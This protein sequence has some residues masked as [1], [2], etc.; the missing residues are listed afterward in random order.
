M[1]K[2][3]TIF[4]LAFA[5]FGVSMSAQSSNKDFIYKKR[6]LSNKYMFQSQE[7]KLGEMKHIFEK[8][9]LTSSLYQKH[10]RQTKFFKTTAITAVSVVVLGIGT[11][12][13][14]SQTG[15][16]YDALIALGVSFFLSVTTGA[17][18]IGAGLASLVSKSRLKKTF[19]KFQSTMYG[20]EVPSLEFGLAQN[21]LGF[22]LRF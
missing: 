18:S 5:F 7:Y 20:Y 19:N 4:S 17:I 12:I 14:I 21:R 2:I 10:R 16:F 8:H 11:S 3:I 13:L 22:T 6:F 15:D 9:Q 1:E